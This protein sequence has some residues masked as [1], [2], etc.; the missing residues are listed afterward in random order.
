ME[1]IEYRFLWRVTCSL[2]SISGLKLDFS[3]RCRY[4]NK[5][6]EKKT[7]F[8]SFLVQVLMELLLTELCPELRTHL[9]QLK[10]C[11]V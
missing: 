7:F 11:P 9:D 6:S 10:A 4:L 8:L 5:S 2:R 1:F 3:L